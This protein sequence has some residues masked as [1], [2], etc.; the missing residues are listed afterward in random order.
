MGHSNGDGQFPGN[1]M[2]YPQF[3]RDLE[4]DFLAIKLAPGI[5][6]RSY[7]KD[8][9]VISEDA[10]GKVLEIQVLSVS[11]FSSGSRSA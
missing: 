8:G 5:E 10:D 6:S 3:F 4:H 11:N 9:C 1:S 2:N 7:V